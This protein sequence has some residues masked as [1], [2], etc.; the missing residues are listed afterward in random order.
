M[1]T[2]SVFGTDNHWTFLIW[3][4]CTYD[5]IKCSAALKVKLVTARNS[6]SYL[7]LA[8]NVLTNFTSS[9]FFFKVIYR[10][11]RTLPQKKTPKNRFH[12]EKKDSICC[13]WMEMGNNCSHKFKKKKRLIL[14]CTLSELLVDSVCWIMKWDVNV[15]VPSEQLYVFLFLSSTCI[16]FLLLFWCQERHHFDLNNCF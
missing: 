11:G 3:I 14:G 15:C 10:S 1:Y 6:T 9:F 2:L 8:F 5:L 13:W 7:S 16:V 4:Y 12:K